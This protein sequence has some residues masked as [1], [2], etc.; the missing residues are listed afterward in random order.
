MDC[1]HSTLVKTHKQ[2][3]PG[4]QRY[5]CPDCHGVWSAENAQK[6]LKF[7][8]TQESNINPYTGL[9]F[10]K[11][12][13]LVEEIEA[14]ANVV[15]ASNELDL[16]SLVD[17]LVNQ[18]II[19]VLKEYELE[20]KIQGYINKITIQNEES[21]IL[22]T[23]SIE[24]LEKK[25]Q[26]HSVELTKLKFEMADFV[27]D[28]AYYVNSKSASPTAASSDHSPH[29][30]P[31]DQPENPTPLSPTSETH[32]NLTQE[33]LLHSSTHQIPLSDRTRFVWFDIEEAQGLL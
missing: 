12:G 30:Q 22:V 18:K 16:G 28:I 2:K 9:P 19:R 32:Q 3:H 1:K 21:I 31:L 7:D 8:E 10:A 14:S 6:R 13:P 5:Y 23:K 17:E 25:E 15:P 33:S 26:E 11:H 4:V 27:K 29:P 24:N 20:F